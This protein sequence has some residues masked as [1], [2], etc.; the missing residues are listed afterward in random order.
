MNN[1]ASLTP[2]EVAD[3]LKIAKTTVYEMIKRGELPCYRIGRKVRV[4]RKDVE[5]YRSSRKSVIF[6]ETPSSRN[7]AEIPKNETLSSTSESQQ[8]RRLIISGQDISLDILCHHLENVQPRIMGLRSYL[9]S[10]NGLISL[11]RKEIDAASVHLWDEKSGTYNTPYISYLLPGVPCTLIHIAKR[12]VGFYV[13]K[14]N[15]LGIS[16][17]RDLS[18]NNITIINREKGSGIRILLDQKLRQMGISPESLNGYNRESQTHLA[19]ASLISQGGAD[20]AIGSEKAALQAHDIEFIPLQNERYDL[21]IRTED[22]N[23]PHFS[24]M[25]DIIR[26]KAYLSELQGLGGYDLSESG[27]ITDIS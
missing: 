12:R 4:D 2:Q 22:R 13:K 26:S 16:G 23:K 8:I 15:P 18:R 25:F 14:G 9:G 7:N 19:A 1:D 10:Y 20:L 24:T 17:W 5:Q 3:I 21:A 6:S 11:Y 27:V